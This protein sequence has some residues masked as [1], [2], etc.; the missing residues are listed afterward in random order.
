MRTQERKQSAILFVSTDE[1]P[2]IGEVIAAGP[3]AEV[4]VGDTIR[5]GEFTFPT[6]SVEQ[7][8]E[9][10]LMMRDKDVAAVVETTG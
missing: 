4:K 9:K 10:L 6:F 2:S 1:K 7:F 8:G 3:E 5:F